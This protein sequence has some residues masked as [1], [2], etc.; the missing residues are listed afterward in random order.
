MENNLIKGTLGQFVTLRYAHS[1]LKLDNILITSDDEVKL[2]DFG[3]ATASTAACEF[4]EKM[5]EERK[6]RKLMAEVTKT[7][8]M[9]SIERHVESAADE[10]KNLK[11][12]KMLAMLKVHART[13]SLTHSLTPLTHPPHSLTHT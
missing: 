7:T 13:H 8:S 4:D 6:E 3:F 9:R 10:R 1:D 11:S 5:S 2:S 12:S